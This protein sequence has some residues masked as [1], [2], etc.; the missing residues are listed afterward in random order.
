[1]VGPRSAKDVKLISAG[2][3]LENHRTVGDCQSPMYD[4]PGGVTTMHV[5]VQE[6]TGKGIMQL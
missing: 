2:K 1:M 6:P 4:V 5:I 3:I